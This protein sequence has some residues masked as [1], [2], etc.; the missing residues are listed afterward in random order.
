MLLHH[1]FIKI[2]KRE[3]SKP[4]FID[5]TTNRRISYSK[6]LI[7]SLILAEKI[8]KCGEGF[9]G[10][11]L[12][13]TAGCALSLIGSLL[14]GRTPVMINYSTG[15]EAN[16]RYAQ[17]KC[18][19]TTIITSRALLE[20][21]A[22]PEVEGMVFIEDIMEGISVTDKV[23]AALRA[24]LPLP[25]LLRSVHRGHPDDDLVI[26]F[27]SGSE[28]DP[29]AVQ[30]S[31]RNISSN[32]ESFSEMAGI[33]GEDR[34]LANLPFFHIFGLTV[35]LWTPLYHGMTAVCYS[36]P[37]DY[38]MVCTIV[39]EHEPTLM[40]GTPSFLWG[41]LRKSEPGDFG[42]VRLAVCGADK[43][44]DALRQE[45]MEKH[46]VTLYEGYGTTE[47]SP[48][49]SANVPGHNRP[50]SIGRVI[51]GVQ[52][53]IENYETGED[54][55]PGQ[56]GRIL[57]KGDLVMKGY[58]DDFEETSMRIRHGWYDTGDMGYLDKD[59]FLWH[60]G[61]LKRFVK[62]GGEM[63]SLVWV[64]SILERFLPEG[65]SCCVVEVPDPVKGAK[66]VA[67]VTHGM[68]ER[69]VLR[70]MAEHLPNIALPRQFVVIEE[71]PK[72]G[73]GKIDFRR[74]T[75][76]VSDILQGSAKGRCNG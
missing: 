34:M 17:K 37:L 23:K 59:G 51:P 39:R 2:A 35:N 67:A 57:V 69:K 53:R 63:V 52:V 60:A 31:H 22:C 32:I 71:L 26:L 56:V 18:G 43:C 50:G 10:I 58:F 12:P 3:G 62:I 4:A 28:R 45:F 76:M 65:A 25:L 21:I 7:G 61:R 74:V 11:M 48:V 68:E 33:S 38:R 66:I 64:E 49:I 16:A 5:L 40:V 30:L 9:I 1:R 55:L 13:T 19:F 24:K 36:N 42:S 44:P 14:A 46:G 47:T 8:R 29:K 54:C 6:A 27:T 15:A 70:Q 75:E 41:Y 20:K 73:S 72:M